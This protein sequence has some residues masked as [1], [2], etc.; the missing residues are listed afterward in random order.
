VHSI[1]DA[2]LLRSLPCWV[3]PAIRSKLFDVFRK[4]SRW[5]KRLSA[6]RRVGE[7]PL[8]VADPDASPCAG[9]RK[10]K[11]IET[12]AVLEQRHI[13]VVSRENLLRRIEAPIA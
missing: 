11:S 1:V 9:K 6:E 8:L 5:G 3:A 7:P 13:V 10:A 12:H 4:A 2:V